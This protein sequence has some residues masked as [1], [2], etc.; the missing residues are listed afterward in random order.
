VAEDALQVPSG[1]Q[2]GPPSLDVLQSAHGPATEAHL[3]FDVG[4]TGWALHKLPDEPGRMIR[5][6]QS[7]IVGG[8]IST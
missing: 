4:D 7:S 2:P 8:N 5:P 6:T 1:A 3:L